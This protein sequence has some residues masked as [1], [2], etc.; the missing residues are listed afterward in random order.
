VV[1]VTATGCEILPTTPA[2]PGQIPDSASAQPAQDAPAKDDKTAK[3]DT[4]PTAA[5]PT[6]VARPRPKASASKRRPTIKHRHRV[7]SH[8]RQTRR[9]ILRPQPQPDLFTIL[10][11]GGA[12]PAAP[13]RQ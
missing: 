2:R 11:G 8:A 12:Q 6:P 13:V 4:D 9:E 5:I 1:A 10:F 3:L 7:A